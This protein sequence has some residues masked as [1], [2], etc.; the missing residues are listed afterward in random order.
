MN[1]KQLE[2]FVAIAETGSFTKGAEI[3]CITQSTAS[4]H[5]AALEQSAGVRLLDRSGRGAVLTQAGK[6]LLQSAKR[7]LS[8]VRNTEQAIRRFS[9]AEGVELRI[10]GS[11]IPGT[12]LVPAA[13]AL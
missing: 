12:Y 7:A 1:I 3:A 2:V 8:A 10:A 6:T 5:I 9:R 11:S 13:V 4:Q